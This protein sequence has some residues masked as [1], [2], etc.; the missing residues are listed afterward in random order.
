MR[1]CYALVDF[2]KK[3]NSHQEKR[4][5]DTYYLGSELPVNPIPH[6]RHSI[7]HKPIICNNPQVNLRFAQPKKKLCLIYRILKHQTT[8]YNP[9]LRNVPSKKKVKAHG[10][11][12]LPPP[13]RVMFLTHG[14]SL[15]TMPALRP[16][17]VMPST[18]HHLGLSAWCQ[19]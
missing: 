12:R 9:R 1:L 19:K 4:I 7:P 16:L 10:T 18:S 5:A 15:P 2:A 13:F 14:R 3:I 8:P 6:P 17:D 11:F